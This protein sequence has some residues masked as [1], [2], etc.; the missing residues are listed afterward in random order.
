MRGALSW[1][2]SIYWKTRALLVPELENSQVEYSRRVRAAIDEHHRWLD[3]G[4]GHGV[5]PAW[6][7]RR[8]P[9]IDVAGK[10]AVGIDADRGAL[11]KHNLFTRR[12]EGNGET[13][14]F[15]DGSFDLITANMVL[16]HVRDP[17]SL[18]KEVA[19]VLGP[20]GLFLI[21]TPNARGPA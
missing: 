13:L 1:S 16:E 21:H 7:D 11:E 18:F 2:E 9:P 12:V 20:G 19:R 15:G 6:L 8:Q 4:C 10:F 17:A 14:P 3:V 5:L